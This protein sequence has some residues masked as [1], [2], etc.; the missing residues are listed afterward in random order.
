MI[1][2]SDASCPRH[3]CRIGELVC[4]VAAVMTLMA[5]VP[6]AASAALSITAVSLVR[7]SGPPGAV[8]IGGI[9]NVAYSTT[10]PNGIRNSTV[11]VD[12]GSPVTTL[13]SIRYSYS[14]TPAVGASG[15]VTA[16]NSNGVKNVNPALP[17]EPGTYAISYQAFSTG[18]CGGSSSTV[19][20]GGEVTVTQPATNP[21]KELECG[22]RVALVLDESLSINE[23]DVVKT[24]DAAKAFVG[25]LG[26]TGASV[27]V[28]AFAQHARTLVP[29]TEVDD[30]TIG[31]DF[32][33]ELNDFANISSAARSGTN[34]QAAFS[35]VTTLGGLP[36]LVVFMTDG[37]P[38]GT[39]ATSGT[40]TGGFTT[41]LDGG[42]DV[43]T[44]AVTA[45]NT[46]K[47]GSRVF[48]IGVG[49]A[50]SSV[51]SVSRLTAVSGPHAGTDVEHSDYTLLD[52]F[53]EL[54][55]KLK[56]IVAGLCG[57]S[58]TITKYD[59]GRGGQAVEASGWTFKATL[60]GTGH[61]WLVPTGT[62]ASR[63]SASVTTGSDGEAVFH[64]KLTGPGNATLSVVTETPKPGFHLVLADC[65]VTDADGV[66][67]ETEPRTTEPIAEELIVPPKG[68]AACVVENTR[69][70][71]HLTVVKRLVPTDDTGRFDLLVNGRPVLV[72]VGNGKIRLTRP[73]GSYEVSEQ[74]S[75]GQAITLAD[76]T[77]T[78]KC[79]NNGAPAGQSTDNAPV[80]VT[81]NSADDDIVCT[82]T[83]TRVGGPP[84]EGGEGEGV[85][86]VPPCNDI[87]DGIPQCGN[88][89]NAPQLM[90]TKRM[91]AQARVGDRLPITITVKN[92]GHATAH[93]VRLHETPP[94]G[95]RIV[96]V[97]DHGS[98]QSDGTVV[99]NLGTLAPGETRTVHATMLITATGL[100]TDMAVASVGNADPAFDVAAVRA[101]APV[102]PPPPA[103]TG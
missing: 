100:S 5:A 9:N 28:I 43:M 70:V 6:A 71:A 83:N 94:P 61:E 16:S 33:P 89:A 93:E 27:A 22:L 20:S 77:I 76:Y 80:R 21:T 79:V 37:D 12:R 38:N 4:G 44:A 14:P 47:A 95:G 63:P 52:H 13:G 82:I 99:W 10:N 84:G 62:L 54:E 98:L 86:P 49:A 46:V 90:V 19:V 64:W 66:V 91:P 65:E 50:V 85:I 48:A 56:G 78:T 81:L 53:A 57:G 35:Q 17:R 60:T 69:T 34:W 45:A 24:R 29:Y 75:A 31:N 67:T 26:D 87:D 18:T 42:V 51:G 3:F 15:C 39:N 32:N 96:E 102:H 8:L 1:G 58:L 36:D 74:V 40:T 92:V 59:Y 72:R 103:V 88:V 2:A 41:S 101:R 30:T 73:L 23:Q 97:A 55:T 25:A 68:H 11:T 7:T